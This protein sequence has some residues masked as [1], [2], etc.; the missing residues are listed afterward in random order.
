MRTPRLLIVASLL[1]LTAC[2]PTIPLSIGLKQAGSD[3]LFGHPPASPPPPPLP[4]A[5]FLPAP[6]ELP[7]PAPGAPP[8]TFAAIP[9]ASP[10]PACPDASPLAVP[11]QPAGLWAATPPAAA[12]YNFRY[13]G[14]VTIDPGQ[15]DQSVSTVPASGT[16]QVIPTSQPSPVDGSYTFSVVETFAG[17]QMKSDF[18]V[19]P[20]ST[21]VAPVPLPVTPHAGIYFTGMTVTTVGSSTPST[22]FNPQPPVQVDVFPDFPGQTWQGGAGTDPASQT[23]LT[24]DGNGTDAKSSIVSGPAR[25][26]AC[27]DVV[28]AWEVT[29][30]GTLSAASSGPGNLTEAYTL[31]LD[32]A[33]QYGGISVQDHLVLDDHDPA[34]GKPR[35]YDVTATTDQVPKTP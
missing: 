19:F 35:H 23:T 16:R 13:R 27:G 34:S 7:P 11:G 30:V 29:L 22:Q 8:A 10:P 33:T 14:T 18:Q 9:A 3:I 21:A 1:S 24:V 26:N 28:Q 6:L 32:L 4:Q 17:K 5:R 12:T 31:V 20:P 2:G 25:V 15:P